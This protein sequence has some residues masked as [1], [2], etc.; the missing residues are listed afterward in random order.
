M[1][2]DDDCD[3]DEFHAHSLVRII[4][5][6]II[7]VAVLSIIFWIARFAL[8]EI[9]IAPYSG[10]LHLIFG[11]VGF[12]LLIWLIIWLIHFLS[13]GHHHHMHDNHMHGDRAE[14]ILRRRYAKG[15]ISEAQYKKM[16]KNL[17]G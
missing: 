13:H 10:V 3:Y 7:F 8:N 9:G 1:S 5:G 17:K 12:I 2:K 4:V 15:E 14:R 6:I 11:V 16:L